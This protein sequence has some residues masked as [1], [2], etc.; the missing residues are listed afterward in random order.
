MSRK[1]IGARGGVPDLNQTRCRVA[2]ATSLLAL[3]VAIPLS[4]SSAPRSPL[5]DEEVRT[6]ADALLA[7]MIPEEKAG[8]LSEYFYFSELPPL[9]KLVDESLDKGGVGALLFVT[10][11]AETNRLQKIATEKTRLKI[12]LLFGFDVIHGFRTIFPVPL[13]MAASWDPKMVEEIQ[14]V[15]A[16]EARAVGIHWAFAPNVD[17]TRDPR[18]GRIVEGAGEDPYLGAAMAAAQVRGFQGP[19]LASPGGKN[20]PIG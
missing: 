10:D 12:P 1:V 8:Q 15:A 18:W 19:F 3:A 17:I 2:L 16:A 13:G 6:R 4:A 20:Q 9:K 7:R 11:P 14:A 5:R